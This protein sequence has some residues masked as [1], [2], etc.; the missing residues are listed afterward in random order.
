MET[1]KKIIIVTGHSTGLGKYIYDRFRIEE[2][3]RFTNIKVCGFDLKEGID[4]SSKKLEQKIKA[5]SKQ[6]NSNIKVLVN[7][8]AVEHIQWIENTSYEEAVKIINYNLL[9]YFWTARNVI[10]Y[11]M[12]EGGIILNIVSIAGK[13]PMRASCLYNVTKAA[14]IMMTKQMARELAD[15]KLSVIGFAFGKIQGTEMT[16]R[17][18][19]K[20]LRVRNW[21]KTEADKYQYSLIPAARALSIEEAGDFVFCIYNYVSKWIIQTGGLSYLTGSVID[22]A[23][24]LG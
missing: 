5:L 14:Q 24:G 7:N 12:G 11:G 9:G 20:I 16:R 21:T 13:S 18:E 1:D 15:K 10:K 4:V 22:C 6:E 17:I 3:N 8:A 19:A 23:G 2:E